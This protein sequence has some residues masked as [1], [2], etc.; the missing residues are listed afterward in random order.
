[1][2]ELICWLA[3]P[4]GAILLSRPLFGILRKRHIAHV[5]KEY[6]ALYQ[7]SRTSNNGFGL[8][9]YGFKMDRWNRKDRPGFIFLAAVWSLAWP[10][11]ALVP[12]VW[13]LYKW[14]TGSKIRSSVEMTAERD[15]LEQRIRELEK[16]LGI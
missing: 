7:Y 10:A 6:P 11:L 12:V 1:M 3:W 13:V 2:I 4:A 15:K 9:Y 16:E 14:M 5:L 8:E